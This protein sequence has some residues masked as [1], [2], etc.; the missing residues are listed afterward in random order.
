[1]GTRFEKGE[2]DRILPGCNHGEHDW[3]TSAVGAGN[4]LNISVVCGSRTRECQSDF[5]V[6]LIS[7]VTVNA[8]HTYGVLVR[9]VSM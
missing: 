9:P 8:I 1:M 4:W 7:Q 5:L 6:E 3:M 2:R